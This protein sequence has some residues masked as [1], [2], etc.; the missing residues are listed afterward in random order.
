MSETKVYP[1][2][3]VPTYLPGTEIEI[4]NG[5]AEVGGF[6][7][8]IFDFDGTVSVLREGWP[9]IMA[10]VMLDAIRGD[11]PV[12]PALEKAVAEFIDES[13]GIQTILQMAKLVEMV[14]E[15]GNVPEDEILD[16]K[17]YKDIYNEALMVPVNARIAKLVS[18]EWT[19]EEVV[20]LGSREFVEAFYE[21]GLTVYIASGTDRDDVRNEVRHCQI[22]QWC[23]GG[24]WGAVGNIEEYSKDKVIK[25]ILAEN[26]LHGSELVVLG[27]GPV[28]IRN[29]KS[30]GAVAIGV[31]SDEVKRS[32]LNVEKRN[33]LIKAGA[34]ILVPDFGEGEK[35]IKYL[36]NE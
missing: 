8:A 25:E 21:R 7:H 30:N 26:N 17:G 22:D 2:P 33:R 34:D 10:P 35:L 20:M 28:E 36:F 16:A 1:V 29:A 19:L 31:A 4:V 15:A 14:G 12:T 32:G 18:G 5:K 24:I 9:E 13:T 6:K 11:T 23:K 3:E 27:D